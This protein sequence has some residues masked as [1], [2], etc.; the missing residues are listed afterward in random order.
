MSAQLKAQLKLAMVQVITQI[1]SRPED[2]NVG[3]DEIREKVK[4][5]QKEAEKGEQANNAKLER[6]LKELEGMADDIYQVTLGALS[7]AGV[8]VAV[9]LSVQRATKGRK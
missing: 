3:N 8:R 5:I 9:D 1:A 4:Q 2:P 7:S 6:W